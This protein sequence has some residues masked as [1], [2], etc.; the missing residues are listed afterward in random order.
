[1]KF[2]FINESNV[3]DGSKDS[4]ALSDSAYWSISSH[5]PSSYC[6]FVWNDVA[7]EL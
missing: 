1:M 2:D 7:S 6:D 3:S 4:L 5:F